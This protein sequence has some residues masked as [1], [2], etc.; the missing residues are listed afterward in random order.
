MKRTIL[1]IAVAAMLCTLA[2]VPALAQDKM[3]YEE[4]QAQLAMYQERETA[5]QGKIA[6]LEA[7]IAGLENDIANLNGQIDNEWAAIYGMLNL[8]EADVDAF[9]A[10]LE[11]LENDVSNFARLSMDRQY[12][13]M[14]MLDDFEG[15]L[16]ALRA[17]SASLITEYMER[18]DRVENQI[19]G[20]RA[21]LKPRNIE[22]TVMR[23]DHLWGIAAKP[24]HYGA[25]SKWMRI[26]SVNHDKID[27]PNLIYPKQ[28]FTIPL[29]LEKDQYLVEG[30]DHFYG[31]AGKLW[32]DPFKWR[33]LYDAN[34][35]LVGEDPNTLYKETILNVPHR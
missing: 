6:T 21:G 5:A 8:T 30:G 15:R 29:E 3:T 7:D 4:Y 33:K 27:D 25:G 35:D 2:A 14:D 20:I 19:A 22:Y 1:F 32:N 9:V 18:L 12:S 26:Y 23:G 11:A 13:Q 24:D 34:R 31:I 16:A 28:V 17:H 10:D